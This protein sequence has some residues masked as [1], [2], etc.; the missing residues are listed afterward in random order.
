MTDMTG[1]ALRYETGRK[2][3]ATPLDMENEE[4]NAGD[5]R[6]RACTA[7]EAYRRDWVTGGNECGDGVT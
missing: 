7:G 4:W 2:R 3:D 5:E 1:Q 6:H